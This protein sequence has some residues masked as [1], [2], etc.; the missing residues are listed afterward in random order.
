MQ[1]R[2]A[3]LLLLTLAGPAA[4]LA[5]TVVTDP[6][7]KSAANEPFHVRIPG[8][9]DFDLPEID[10]PGTIKLILHPHLGDIIRRD[11]M[12]VDTGFRWAVNDHFEFTP[13]GRVYFG[14]NHPAVGVGEARLSGKYV[15]RQ[16]PDPDL[17]T[18]FTLTA[19][20]PIK[21]AP[22]DMTDGMDHLAPSFVI[23]H[24]SHRRPKWTTFGGA[25]VDLVDQSEVAGTPWRNEPLDDSMNF[26][27]G[28]IYDLGQIKWTLTGTYATTA[29]IGDETHH[30]FYLQPNVLWY[31]P[32]KWTFNSK[33]QWI[34]VLGA[35][36]SWGPDG[37]ELSF[38]NRVRA[39]I[40]F[41]QVMDKVRTVIPGGKDKP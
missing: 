29:W 38:S 24:H 14:D 25:G 33:T 11:Y 13:S 23:Q 16:W 30:F 18:S 20:K 22:I 35:R 15:L 31:V 8:L 39:E 3:L 10:P 19:S 17:E 27:A 9:F 5:Q 41:R 26:T 28:A 6:S 36:A 1:R 37:S 40:T 34:L 7:T 32:K 12:R 2:L 4:A 21:D